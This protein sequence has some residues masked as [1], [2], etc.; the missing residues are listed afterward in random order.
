MLRLAGKLSVPVAAAAFPMTQ[1]M[2]RRIGM[3][4]ISPDF[5]RLLRFGRAVDVS[6]LMLFTHTGAR[7]DPPRR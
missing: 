5:G 6:R 3:P 4:A 1:R 7:I 2:G